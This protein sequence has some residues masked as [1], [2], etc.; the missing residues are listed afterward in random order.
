MTPFTH[1]EFGAYI[2]RLRTALQPPMTQQELAKSVDVT[3]GF[4]AHVETGRT[5]PAIET[6]KRLAHALGVDEM[7][8]LEQAGMLSETEA[9]LRPRGIDDPELRLFFRD[10]WPDLNEFEREMLRSLVRMLR[11]R[12]VPEEDQ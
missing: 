1:S 5:L 11:S 7:K 4:I 10:N 12:R 9:R 6:C 3:N 2:R 8:L